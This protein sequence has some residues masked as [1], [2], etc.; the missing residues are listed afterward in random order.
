M[1]DYSFM[2]SGFDNVQDAVDDEELKKNVVAIIVKFSEGALNTAAKYVHHSKHRNT[3]TPEDLKRAM[4]LE[5]FL[6][7]HR[8]NLSQEVEIL[9]EELFGMNTN[10][11]EEMHS[12]GYDGDSDNDEDAEFSENQCSCPICRTINNIYSTWSTL[13]VNSPY[14]A[15]LKQHIENM[16]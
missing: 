15:L 13:E 16:C 7:K 9:K 4:M 6:F 3:V 10:E 11:D 8:E 1:S 12:I 5:M 14:E 2:K